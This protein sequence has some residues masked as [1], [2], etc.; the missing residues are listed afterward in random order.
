MGVL[1]DTLWALLA[2]TVARSLR[3]RSRWAEAPRYV[4]GGLLISL[5]LATAFSGSTSRK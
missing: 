2:G 3:S 1:S 5:G 4:S